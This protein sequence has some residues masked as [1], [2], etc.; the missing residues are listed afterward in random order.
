M[1]HFY[2]CRLQWNAWDCDV[3]GTI[4]KLQSNFVSTEAIKCEEKWV[5]VRKGHLDSALRSGSHN[6]S[7]VTEQNWNL[8][9]RRREVI[10]KPQKAKALVILT[11]QFHDNCKNLICWRLCDMTKHL[12][13]FCENNSCHICR[14]IWSF[15]S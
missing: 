13:L 14:V 4:A 8:D 15:K 9:Q 6:I 7:Q 2:E 12:M 11:S 5:T 10:E 3:C 1:L